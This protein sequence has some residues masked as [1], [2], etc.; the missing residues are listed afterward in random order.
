MNDFYKSIE[1]KCKE[2]IKF[3][4]SS[5]INLGTM[6]PLDDPAAST[7]LVERSASDPMPGGRKKSKKH[8]KKR[9][10]FRKKTRK[11]R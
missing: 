6:S 2:D 8:K 10:N 4:G 9:N 1:E 11:K 5:D 3:S 7:I